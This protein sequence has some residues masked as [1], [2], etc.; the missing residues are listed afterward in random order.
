MPRFGLASAAEHVAAVG[1]R[2]TS[3]LRVGGN[4]EPAV[5]SP[6]NPDEQFSSS[7]EIDAG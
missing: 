2:E 5:P 1:S 6:S 4:N 7:S 3:R